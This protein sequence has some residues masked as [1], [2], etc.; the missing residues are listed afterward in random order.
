MPRFVNRPHIFEVSVELSTRE[1]DEL[2]RVLR[3]L[4]V[5]KRA[6]SRALV[7]QI[8]NVLVEQTRAALEKHLWWQRP[9]YHSRKAHL[10]VVTQD[11]E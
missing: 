4:R 6:A 2:S 11:A 5:S 10:R 3:E 9:P 7:R 8:D 1:Y